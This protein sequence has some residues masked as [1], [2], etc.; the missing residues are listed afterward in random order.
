[1]PHLLS[2][3]HDL[4]CWPTCVPAHLWIMNW[5]PVV[6][7][8]WLS[9]AKWSSPASYLQ[10][11]T[12]TF[13]TLSW[14]CPTYIPYSVLVRKLW[15]CKI[16]ILKNWH[17]LNKSENQISKFINIVW[18]FYLALE[19]IIIIHT[20]ASSHWPVT[21]YVMY[22]LKRFIGRWKFFISICIVSYTS[23]KHWQDITPCYISSKV[24]LVSLKGVS[25]MYKIH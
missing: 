23:K 21:I 9:A 7:T 20:T 14:V 16:I 12:H 3:T 18:A 10:H 25:H 4:K 2:Q 1:M 22:G 5:C 24:W 17:L 13:H 11:D 19:T 8:V 15:T 6:D